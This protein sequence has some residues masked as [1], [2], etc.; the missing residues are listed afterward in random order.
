MTDK[1]YFQL[2]L[3]KLNEGAWFKWKTHDDDGNEIPKEDRVTYE[4]IVVS[5]SSISKPTLVEVNA[6]IK[7]LKDIDTARENVK[8]SGNQKL[9]DLGLTQAEATALTGYTPPVAE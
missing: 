1:E 5:N 8:A 3:A 9:L 2:A 4:N 6:K 7:E